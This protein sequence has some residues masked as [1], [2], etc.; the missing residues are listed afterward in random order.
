MQPI[1]PEA[2][3]N[4]RFGTHSGFKSDIAQDP[5]SAHE[6]KSPLCSINSSRQGDHLAVTSFGQPGFP[7]SFSV[8]R[9]IFGTPK[10]AHHVLEIGNT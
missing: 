6:R 3:A 7:Q 9:K 8:S 2:W 4:V 1:N 5:K 10:R